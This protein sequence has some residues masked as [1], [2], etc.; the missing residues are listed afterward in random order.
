MEPKRNTPL[1]L[2]SSKREMLKSK[3]SI[4]TQRTHSL[5]DTI[6]SPHGLSKKSRTSWV[7]RMIKKPQRTSPI[8]TILIS[9]TKWTGE[10]EEPST[11]SKLK[12]DAVLAGLSQ[13]L[14]QL[15][16]LTSK[17]QDN[18][19]S[20]LS[21]NLLTVMLPQ[22]DV[23]EVIQFTHSTISMPTLKNLSNNTHTPAN[24]ECADIKE[25]TQLPLLP[26]ET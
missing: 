24:K 11:Q 15:K 17:L 6:S 10:L 9:L 1:D 19:Q 5:L 21:K 8:L 18:S 12:V 13:P 7:S 4:Q 3:E 14:P 26:T 25:L 20:F 23:K 2:K 22:V 16:L